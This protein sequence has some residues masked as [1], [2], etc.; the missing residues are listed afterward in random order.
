MAEAPALHDRAVVIDGL[1]VSAWSPEV[2]SAMQRG[3]VTAANCT[4]C[5]WE[6]FEDT[7]RQVAQW[8]RWLAEHADVITQVHGVEDIVRAKREGRVGIILGWQ[9]TSGFDD[10][11][12]FVPLFAEL[13]LRVV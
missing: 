11:L 13:G 1:N 5:I 12:P 3:G 2:F 7:M 10:H 6:G 8:K 4:C 9:N